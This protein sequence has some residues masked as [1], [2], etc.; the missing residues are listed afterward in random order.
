MA[1]R[2]RVMKV[3]AGIQVAGI[4]GATWIHLQDG[5]GNATKGDHDLT[6][7]TDDAVSVGELVVAKGTLQADPKIGTGYERSLL[8][9]GAKVT[10]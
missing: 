9:P 6:V 1:I 4:A 8:L 7:T 10:K 3:T 5:S 2:G